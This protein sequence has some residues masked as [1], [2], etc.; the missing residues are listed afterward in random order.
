MASKEDRLPQNVPGKFYV[1]DTCI[2]C[3]GCR[4]AAPNNFT[5]DDRTGYSYCFKQP[6]NAT[7]W[8][9]C[10]EAVQGCPTESVGNDGESAGK[11]G[12]ITL[13]SPPVKRD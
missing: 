2:D 12:S 9:E 8:A 13:D 4:S 10:E 7:E 1:D 11:P 6:E 5:R 3:D